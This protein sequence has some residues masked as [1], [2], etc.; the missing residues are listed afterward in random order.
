MNLTVDVG[1]KFGDGINVTKFLNRL[2]G[3]NMNRQKFI[4]QYFLKS[5]ENEVSKAKTA[6]S[7]D[8]GI[9]TLIGNNVELVSR[10][11]FRFRGLAAK[12]DRVFVYK[13]NQ[14]QGTS[15]ETAMELFNDAKSDMTPTRRNSNGFI[16]RGQRNEIRSGWYADKRPNFKVTPKI[17]LVINPGNCILSWHLVFSLPSPFH[18]LSLIRFPQRCVHHDKAQSWP[19]HD[20]EVG[21]PGHD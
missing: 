12:D 4:T 7:Y 16:G 10:R 19:A 2:L 9:R 15:A 21:Y 8:I 18:H 5:L 6:G 3:M 11:C 1:I 17:F 13:V 20:A 14:D